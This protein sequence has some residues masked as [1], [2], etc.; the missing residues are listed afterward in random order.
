M[1]HEIKWFLINLQLKFGVMAS[2]G[3]RAVFYK[4][5]R[6][7]KAGYNPSQT[8]ETLIGYTACCAFVIIYLYLMF[9]TI[10]PFSSPLSIYR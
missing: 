4:G 7:V 9:T 10:L 1:F 3:L 8:S 5:T 2:R 6:N